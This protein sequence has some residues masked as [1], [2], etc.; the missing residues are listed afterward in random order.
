MTGRLRRTHN[1][2]VAVLDRLLDTGRGYR[3]KRSIAKSLESIAHDLTRLADAAERLSPP[4][5]APAPLSA[6]VQDV[7]I[8]EQAK[9]E[10]AN[11]D[12]YRRHRR[13]PTEEELVEH[14]EQIR[15]LL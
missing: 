14:L 1:P 5:V 9:Y 6:E 11:T 7:D 12:F 13:Y 8:S 4:T 3:K 2:R 15:H 10:L